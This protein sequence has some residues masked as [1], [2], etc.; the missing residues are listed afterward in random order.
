MIPTEKPV[1][2]S[3]KK[4]IRAVEYRRLA[5]AAG[6]LAEASPLANVR[7]K[8]ELAAAQWTALA[9]LDERLPQFAG[10]AS[11]SAFAAGPHA[12]PQIEPAAPSLEHKAPAAEARG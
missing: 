12:L 1:T 8:H 10:A 4:E 3:G 11:G 9:V 7:E 2:A 6:A 5:A